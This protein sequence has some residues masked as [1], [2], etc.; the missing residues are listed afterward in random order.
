MPEVPKDP[1][2]D[3]KYKTLMNDVFFYYE[4]NIVSNAGYVYAPRFFLRAQ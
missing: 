1:H 2:T 4:I 3:N